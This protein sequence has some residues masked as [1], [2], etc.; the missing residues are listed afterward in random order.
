MKRRKEERGLP[1]PAA[2]VD[3]SESDWVSAVNPA[4]IRQFTPLHTSLHQRELSM[5]QDCGSR[6]WSLL[7]P[8][9]FLVSESVVPYAPHLWFA[10]LFQ[11]NQHLFNE[12]SGMAM[13]VFLKR[14]HHG[15]I[16]DGQL[17]T[18]ACL[19]YCGFHTRL[20]L[21]IQAAFSQ[22]LQMTSLLESS[23][24]CTR[25]NSFHQSL[26]WDTHS[27]QR[28]T[29]IWD[30][31][32]PISLPSFSPLIAIGMHHDLMSL[33]IYSCSFPFSLLL[34]CVL[35]ICKKEDIEFPGG[36]MVKNLPTRRY[37]TYRRYGFSPWAWK[38]LWSRK[39]QP[40]PVF[41][42]EK[43]PGQRSLAGYR[44]W[45]C[46]ESYT[47]EHTLTYTCILWNCKEEDIE[48]F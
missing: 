6:F 24:Y 14:T 35:W 37:R 22:W 31:S 10:L 25:Q 34:C 15:R 42:P 5:V 7:K 20:H 8:L 39:W 12:S 40:T 9:L 46:K 26:L 32:C 2:L 30:F 43:F 4:F 28:W 27:L 29:M 18:V 47:T 33:S 21:F 41:L 19:I 1:L 16:I 23:H 11:L 36:A 48:F 45:G 17:P 13:G 38:I 3:V 44:L